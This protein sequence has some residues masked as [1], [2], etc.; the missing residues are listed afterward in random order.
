VGPNYFEH[1][2]LKKTIKRS[3]QHVAASFGRHTRLLKEPQLLVLM[4][5][6]ILPPDDK[7]SLVEEPGMTVTPETFRQHIFIL[8]RYFNIIKLA[9][10]IQLKSEGKELPPRSCA[11]TFDDGWVDNFEFAFPVLKELNVPATI[12]LVSDMVGK[13]EVFWP[14][15]LSR[16]INVISRHYPQHWA[17]PELEWLQKDSNNY[18]FSEKLPT[19]EELSA[20]IANTKSYSDQEVND[21]L[22]HIETV[23]QID[24]GNHS[25]SLLNWQQ[26]ME[27]VH[28]GLVEI[29]SHTCHH[30]R[31]NEQTP[32]ELIKNEIIN[33]KAE[34][35]KNIGQTIKTFCFPNGDY[36]PQSLELVRQN[37]TGAVTTQAG[38]NT[39][40][41]DIHKL[42]RIGIHQDI[43]Q[44]K[45]AFLAR[46]SGWM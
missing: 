32:G 11:I 22:A 17:H 15:R 37:Y 24:T 38:W 13:N 18:R 31:L 8:K 28:S 4:Y 29:G 3:L 34:I 12:F 9:D 6:R 5:H 42:Q 7:R 36:C 19:R 39:A 30:L 44:D 27:M 26:V 25:P 14:E 1:K 41:T 40:D 10:W 2:N 46:I 16:L 43:A 23:L 33:S 21:R 45:T 20:L 35:E